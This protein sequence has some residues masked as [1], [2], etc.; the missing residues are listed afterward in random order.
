MDAALFPL[1]S[2]QL[3]CEI[4]QAISKAWSSPNLF[5]LEWFPNFADLQ[6]L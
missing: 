2:L 6:I 1:K 5:F 4:I 3:D